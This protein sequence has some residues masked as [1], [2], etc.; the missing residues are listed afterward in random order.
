VTAIDLAAVAR[1]RTALRALVVAHPELA[2]PA[3]MVRLRVYL[4]RDDTG[5]ILYDTTMS[6]ETITFTARLPH[7]LIKL[8]DAEAKRLGD[9]AGGITVSRNDALRVTLQ[10]A[11]TT[12]PPVA[13][14]PVA[15]EALSARRAI[16]RAP[17]PAVSADENTVRARY[18]AAYAA[19]KVKG[20][21][22]AKAIGCTETMLRRWRES[23]T[24][25]LPESALEKLSALLE[26]EGF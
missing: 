25:S 23:D 8:L 13:P 22:T 3:A 12:A 26:R 2:R 24:S 5:Y 9:L 16:E 7:S 18:R 17:A 21:P 4:H 19:K 1:A 11:L 14:A 6:D 10:R 15:P 20:N